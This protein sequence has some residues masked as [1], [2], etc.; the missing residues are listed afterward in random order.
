M[1]KITPLDQAA[2]ILGEHY[3]N[4]LIVINVGDGICECRYDNPYAAKTLSEQ[5]TVLIADSLFPKEEFEW[6]W[7]DEEEEEEEDF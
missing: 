1:D 6:E 2:G 3:E 4:F 5:G 7:E